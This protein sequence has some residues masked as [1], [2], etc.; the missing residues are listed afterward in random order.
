MAKSVVTLGVVGL[1]WVGYAAWPLSEFYVPVH[2]L[3]TRD[4]ETVVRHVYFDSVRRSL[5]DQIVTAY[6]QRTGVNL[7]RDCKEAW[8][9]QPASSPIRSCPSS[10]RLRT[11]E[12]G[13]EGANER[14]V[15]ARAM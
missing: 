12:D 1:M 5:A 6:V 7:A 13:Q 8:L 3:E 4:V 14:P 11:R 15:H 10:Y 2:A 9:L